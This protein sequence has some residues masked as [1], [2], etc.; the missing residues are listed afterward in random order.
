VS[1]AHGAFA[2]GDL[3]AVLDAGLASRLDEIMHRMTDCADG[4]DFDAS[5]TS[6]RRAPGPRY[7]AAICAVE[8]AAAMAQQG[9]VLNDLLL[10]DPARLGF[11]FADNA[12]DIARAAGV[13]VDFVRAYA[14]LL[15]LPDEVAT[16]LGNILFALALDT[17]INNL[18]LG[19]E[20]RIQSS[21]V[22]TATQTTTATTTTTTSSTSS[23]CPNAT[24]T[25]VSS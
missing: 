5:Q 16:Q 2:T 11:G 15:A 14:P 20:N 21:L 4:R 17:L 22:T 13:A 1:T 18:P 23:G 8:G 10:I 19:D 12:G 9:G 7:G 3:A 6:R 25:P 24:S